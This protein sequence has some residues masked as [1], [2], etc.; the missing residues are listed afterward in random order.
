MHAV[1][2]WVACLA[3]V[4]IGSASVSVAQSHLNLFDA[5][6][7]FQAAWGVDVSYASS[8]LDGLVTEWVG[9]VATD[10]ES[11]LDVLLRGL[12]VTFHRPSSG[13]FFLEPLPEEISILTGI[14]RAQET[15]IPLRDVHISLVGTPEGTTS[16]RD[17]QFSLSTTP[18]SSARV[19]ISH[20]GYHS[21]I[22]EVELLADS[23]LSIEIWLSEWVIQGLP[24]V[25]VISTPLPSE[26]LREVSVYPFEMDTRETEDLGQITGLGTSDLVRNLYDIVGVDID[27]S[28][29]DIHI[30]GG[31][32]G[33]HQFLLDGGKIFEPIHLGL[34]GVFNPFAIRQV[35]VHK[36]GFD[37]T[38][39]SSTAGIIN[40]EHSIDAVKA[41]VVQVDP[42]SFNG[43]IA[44]KMELGP[45]TVSIM[46]AFRNS[47]WNRWWSNMRSESIDRLL[48]DW[49][50]PDVFLMRASL[51]P[52]KRVFE[53]AYDRLINR[54]QIVPQP[55]LPDIYFDDLHAATKIEWADNKEAGFSWYQ[56]HSTLEGKL[57]SA[58]A[59]STRIVSPDRHAW[60]N[61][62]MRIYWEQR[63]TDRFSWRTS[64]RRGNYELS[65]DY[66]GLDRQN[67]V[68][69]AFN[70]YRYNAIKTSDQNSL[71]NNDIGVSIDYSSPQL[72]VRAGLDFSR[73]NH[74]F[75]IQHVFPRVLEHERKSRTSSGYAQQT[76]SP[77]PWTELTTGLRLT[78]LQV[79]DRFHLEP[80]AAILFKS[81]YR[82]GYGVSLRLATGVYY[83]FLNQFEIATISPS[84]IVPSTRFWLPIDET[85][86][87]PLAYHY[88]VDMAAQLWTYWRFGLEYYYKNQRRLYRI[89][90][91]LLWRQETDSPPITTINEFVTNT[92][93]FAF[94]TAAEL[95]R[96]GEKFDLE[97]RYEYSGSRREYTFRNNRPVFLP[98]PWNIPRQF[99]TKVVVRPIPALEGTVRWRGAWGRKWG[100]QQTYYDL[101]GSSTDYIANF[102]GYSFTDPTAPGHE[103][104]PFSQFDL[105]L[106]VLIR[107]RTGDSTLQ[108]RLD[109]LNAFDRMN[110]AYR[111]L[112]EQ[113]EFEDENQNLTDEISHLL[114]R[115]F[116]FSAQLRW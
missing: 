14:V 109:V 42:I 110:P 81:P 77:W 69:A 35:T 49:N 60:E 116:T 97:L 11:D 89:D 79:Q 80:R 9:P 56:G 87:A 19:A 73:S 7:R 61:Q 25:E 57:L 28:T 45:A 5:I 10:A 75:S 20:I 26:S 103:L 22:R 24:P 38:L 95:L 48:K 114:R 8:T 112:R 67:S 96:N 52:L 76:W 92:H 17:G 78:W 34:F 40:A 91:P 1:I 47:V 31:A 100:F 54:L 93:G 55:L 94:G 37:V 66:G 62:S 88:S 64:W 102:D 72:H 23:T 90:Y 4:L 21:D 111:Y 30:Q 101:L 39:G 6:E 36:A 12:R 63:L 98:V 59:D 68:H 99:Q 115:T 104:A 16:N 2:R 46:G 70:V 53:H 15:G 13:T 58:A 74:R 85:N 83:Q 50:R 65:H 105:A 71:M 43:R 3:V 51:Y 106:A 84:T 33:E 82:G 18:R 113:N 107:D 29:G 32:R 41:I 27:L 108:L 44:S 86:R